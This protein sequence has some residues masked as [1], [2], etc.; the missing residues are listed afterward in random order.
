VSGLSLDPLGSPGFSIGLSAPQTVARGGSLDIPVTFAPA[1]AGAA[2][3]SLIIATD[4]GTVEVP[5]SGTGVNVAP[6]QQQIADI[7]AFFDASVTAGTLTGWAAGTLAAGRRKALRNMI[8]AAGDQATN[9]YPQKFA[10]N[11]SNLEV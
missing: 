9:Q 4:V 5:L 3:N 1:V 7:F 6:P 11:L 10:H 8:E 2:S